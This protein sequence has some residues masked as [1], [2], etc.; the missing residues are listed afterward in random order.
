MVRRGVARNWR[1]RHRLGRALREDAACAVREETPARTCREGS[2]WLR[3]AALLQRA[4]CDVMQP[5]GRLAKLRVRAHEGAAQSGGR[6]ERERPE[7]WIW[8]DVAC[9]A[10]ER[11]SGE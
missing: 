1:R 8:L 10:G 6:E 9:A 3:A 5:I 4:A 7:G 11:E 2:P